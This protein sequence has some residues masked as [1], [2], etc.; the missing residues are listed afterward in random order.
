ML[1]VK[2]FKKLRKQTSKPTLEGSTEHIWPARWAALATASKVQ[3][4]VWCFAQ[5]STLTIKPT[6]FCSQFF[7]HLATDGHN[8]P[9]S[10]TLSQ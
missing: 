1:N 7:N 2:C 8:L 5:E 3:L 4:G 9:G 10:I 6:T